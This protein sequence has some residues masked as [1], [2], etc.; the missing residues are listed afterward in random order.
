MTH[1]PATTLYGIFREA[2]RRHPDR[3]ALEGP[4]TTASYA[5]LDTAVAVQAAALREHGVRPGDVVGVVME[6]GSDLVTVVL[7]VS[8]C[9]AAWLTVDTAHPDLRIHSVL[10]QAGPRCLLADDANSA[11]LAGLDIPVRAPVSGRAELREPHPAAPAVTA[12]ADAPAYLVFTSGSTGEP[13]GVVVSQAGL[14]NLAAGF[15]DATGLTANDRVIQ[16]SSSGF[17]IFV[18]ELTMAFGVGATLCVAAPEDLIVGAPLETTLRRRHVTAAVLSPT[19]HGTLD[20]QRLPGLRIL[21]SGAEPLTPAALARWCRPDRRVFNAYGPS[22]ATC[23]ISIGELGPGSRTIDVGRLLTGFAVALVDDR[24]RPVPP[25]ATGELVVFGD[26]VAAG[27]LGAAAAESD[28]FRRLPHPRT[29]RPAHAYRTGDLAEL[30]A[31][32]RL[33]I[34]GRIGDQVKI[35]G[36]RVEPGEVDAV[37]EHSPDVAQ[38]RTRAVAGTD[39]AAVLRTYVVPERDADTGVLAAR[40]RRHLAARLPAAM[41]PAVIRTVAA[42]PMNVN[43]KTDWAALERSDDADGSR[44]APPP[45]RTEQVRAVLDRVLREQG[46]G[47]G[48]L[49]ADSDF[50]LSGGNSLLLPSVAELLKQEFGLP[51]PLRIVVRRRTAA[52]IAEWIDGEK[53]AQ[54][55]AA[56]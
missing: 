25:G 39:G 4:G 37:A 3:T 11:R 41:M 40:L 15:R 55:A 49:A 16:F 54:P 21:V 13:K 6:R 34:R 48:E 29:G 46:L 24:L 38:S 47:E 44:P 12:P 43:G 20:P 32:G 31:D 30:G 36:H 42:I 17:D 45:D 10:R 1:R 50:F 51:V 27:Y 23:M 19:V 26:G 8:A 5:E 14:A 18:G 7:A 53:T 52:A 28:A 35:R 2:A 9:G 56:P 33:V 22:E